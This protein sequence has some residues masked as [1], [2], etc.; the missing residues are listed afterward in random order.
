MPR[1]THLIREA[2]GDLA[3]GDQL[4][5]AGDE[6][7]NLFRKERYTQPPVAHIRRPAIHL[8]TVSLVSLGELDDLLMLLR[9][10]Q[11]LPAPAKPFED[12]PRLLRR[13]AGGTEKIA[14][15]IA[16]RRG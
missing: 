14:Q 7:V 6:G 4:N 13:L 1:Q 16:R 5:F 2:I 11:T 3:R 8:E 12:F 9:C 15:S 10:D